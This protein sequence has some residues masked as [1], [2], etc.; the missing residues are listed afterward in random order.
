[1][2]VH[3]RAN[4]VA[5]RLSQRHSLLAFGLVARLEFVTSSFGLGLGL[6]NH[7]FVAVVF[8]VSVGVVVLL[9]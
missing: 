2:H 5:L 4:V 1:M 3:A 7:V 9:G 8:K 6:D